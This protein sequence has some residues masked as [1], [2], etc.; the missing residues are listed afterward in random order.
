MDWTDFVFPAKHVLG[1]AANQGPDT[2]DS[3]NNPST[4][5]S[6]G[7]DMGKLA[8]SQADRVKQ[9]FTGP[10]SVYGQ[11]KQ[12][13]GPSI[14]KMGQPGTAPQPTMDQLKGIGQSQAPCPM[15]GK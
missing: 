10:Q 13:M 2:Q 14:P 6:A 3:S 8:Q 12:A 1:Q 7:L 4:Q 15:C 11:V 9:T 5:G